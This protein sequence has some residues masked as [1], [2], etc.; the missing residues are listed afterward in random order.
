MIQFNFKGHEIRIR[1]SDWRKLKERFNPDNAEW[2]GKVYEIGIPC[3]LCVRYKDELK[4]FNRCRKCP[5]SILDENSHAC[6]Y[7]MK[8]LFK[9]QYLIFYEDRINWKRKN[10]PQARRQLKAIL[11]RMGEIEASQEGG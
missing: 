9:K 1:N 6:I 3:W 10:N 5:L 7:L 4:I 2:N 11:R 8:K